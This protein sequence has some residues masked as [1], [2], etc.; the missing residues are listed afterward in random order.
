MDLSRLAWPLLKAGKGSVVFIAGTSPRAPVADCMVGAS[1]VAAMLAF[2]KALADF[3]KRD[4]V[5][6]NAVDP[7]S[8]KTSF[9][10]SGSSV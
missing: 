6:V 8:V 1:V 2:M 3:G 9:S 10:F 5:Q 4:G 7:G